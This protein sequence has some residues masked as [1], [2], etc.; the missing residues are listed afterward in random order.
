MIY[1][2]ISKNSFSYETPVV[3]ASGLT[4]KANFSNFSI[5]ILFFV[6]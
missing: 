5:Q 4:C 2:E 6:Y 1:F 3:A